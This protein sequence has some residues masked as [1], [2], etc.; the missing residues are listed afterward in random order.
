MIEF[1]TYHPEDAE[2][3]LVVELSGQLDTDSAETFFEKL[4]SAIDDGH[5]NIIFDC[6][7]LQH[8]SS[9]GFGMMIRSHSRVQ[10]DGGMVRFARLEGMIEEAF[11][12][13][14]FHKLFDNY[15][16]IDA[17]AQSIGSKD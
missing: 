3:I 5:V 1:S 17:A 15:P 12:I 2:H 13:V 16:T 8:I 7:K 11:N 4:E 10:R 9:L 6:R 14:G